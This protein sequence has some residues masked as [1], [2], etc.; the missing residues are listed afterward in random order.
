[1]PC[2][3]PLKGFRSKEL[4]SSG[5][6]S[7][8]FNM[9]AG[10][11]DLP[12]SLPCGQCVGCRLERSRQWAM[13]IMHEAQLHEDNC[14]ITLTYDDEHL[15]EDRSLKVRH[16]QLFMKRL[17]KQNDHKIRFF[18]CGEYGETTR[19]PHYHAILFNHDFADK[20]PFKKSKEDMLYTS[21]TLQDL[22]TY[23]F[24]TIG[25]VT[26]ESAA[27]CARYVMKKVTGDRAD[28]HYTEIDGGTGEIVSLAPEYC[29][30]SRRP[31]IGKDWFDKYRGDV[32]PRSEVIINGK[33]CK[34]PKYYDRLYQ[35]QEERKYREIRGSRVRGAKKH[36][37]D[38]T[39]QRLKVREAVQT[40]KLR[41]LPRNGE[42]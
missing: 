13:R 15:P 20:V 35:Q 3:R 5:K 19:R 4:N 9:R 37:K 33:R 2:Y 16:F 6:R 21:S 12:V 18:H 24:S 25:N 22:W 30:M 14:F 27:Y 32:F 34:P 23:G 39:P 31:G 1:M 41:Q 42:F 26:F 29:T 36:V 17:R 8:V 10:F 28:D 38:Q 11:K 7:I 40:K